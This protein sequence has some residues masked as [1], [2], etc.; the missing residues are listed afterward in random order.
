MYPS[1]PNRGNDPHRKPTQW[2]EPATK[3]SSFN[4][5]KGPDAGGARVPRKPKPT[6]P[7]APAK[8]TIGK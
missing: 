6:M 5:K 2:P 8:K 7:S 4:N 3:G 1:V